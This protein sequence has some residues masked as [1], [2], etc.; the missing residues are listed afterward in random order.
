[1]CTIVHGDG[2][3]LAHYEQHEVQSSTSSLDWL[4]LLKVWVH[5]S[6]QRRELTELLNDD[7]LLNDIGVSRLD[8]LREAAKPFWMS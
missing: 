3:V 7:H 4:A 8:A 5:R 6:R 2:A 1:M